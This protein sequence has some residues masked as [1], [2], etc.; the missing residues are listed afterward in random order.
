MASKN[1]RVVTRDKILP[2]LILFLAF[3][4][5]VFVRLV[6]FS[7]MGKDYL[8]YASAIKHF[9]RGG[10]PYELT[11]ETYENEEDITKHGFAF[12]PGFLYI[13]TPLFKL[14]GPTPIPFEVFFKLIILLADIGIGVL[15]IKSIY[16]K[17]SEESLWFTF[18]A[19]LMWYLN[20]D[21]VRDLNYV[22]TDPVPIFFMFLALYLVGSKTKYSSIKS[23]FY[24]G[25]A[26]ATKT[27][28]IVIFPILLFKSKNKLRFVL[29]GLFVGFLV[30]IPFLGD[31]QTY[32]KGSLLVHSSRPFQGKPFIYY[33]S[34]LY[35][36]EFLRVIPNRLYS[37]TAIFG[38]WI[39][40]VILLFKEKLAKI[41]K[42]K[43]FLTTISFINF[44]IFTPVLNR[45]YMIWFMPFGLIA[46]NEAVEAKKIKRRHAYGIALIF[47]V[48][49]LWYLL[50]WGK[51]L[52]V[53]YAYY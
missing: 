29:S 45:T 31:L 16:R 19:L 53:D 52:H 27:F 11:I 3:C 48:F 37:F 2:H 21:I 49:Y 42:N 17:D 14:S 7:D 6:N 32:I 30:S 18:F 46:L 44:Y 33:I 8:D 34:F 22:F 41:W 5:G 9:S 15:I 38:G 4:V 20:P 36:I 47:Y 13:Y 24:F 39:V 28:P 10:N 1:T 23:G 40:S 35:G 50:N 43:Y 26:V 51:G 12:L 25:V